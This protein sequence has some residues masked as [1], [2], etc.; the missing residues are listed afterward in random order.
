MQ[1]LYSNGFEAVYDEMYQTFIDYKKEYDCYSKILLKH[2]KK[3][4]LEIGSGTANLAKYFIDNNFDYLGLD[5]SQDMVNL[6]KNKLKK[7]CFLQGDM[8]SFTLKKTVESIIITGRTSS[9]L[10]SNIDLNNALKSIHKNLNKDGILCFD[11]ID[12]NRFIMSIKGGKHIKHNAS[13]NSKHYHRDSFL[14]PTTSDN[15]MFQ[16]D[17]KYYETTQLKKELIAEDNSEVRV[18]TKNEWEL[19]LHLNDFELLEFID[20]PAYMFDTFVVVAKKI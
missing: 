12:A 11:F 8:R 5:Y 17:S 9:Y 7:D 14:Y 13:F 15:F 2:N 3:Q 19:F 10:L 1:S 4:L 20:K 6:A 16:W 18:F